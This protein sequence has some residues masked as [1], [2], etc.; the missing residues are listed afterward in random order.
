MVWRFS[1]KLLLIVSVCFLSALRA[2]NIQRDTLSNG[3]VILLSE[4]HKIPMVEI[5]VIVKAGSVLDPVGKAGLANLAAKM[6]I[7]GTRIHS[8][9]ELLSRIEYLGADLNAGATEDYAEISARALSKDL[10]LLLEIISECLT[11]PLFDT[12]EFKRLQR[13]TYSEIVSQMDDPFYIG[14]VEFRSLLFGKHPLNHDPLGFDSTINNISITDIKD[15]YNMYYASNNAALVLV[16]DFTYDSAIELMKRYFVDW[17]RKTITN[18][19]GTSPAVNGKRG[20]IVKRDISQS[21]IFFGFSGPDYKAKD[22]IQTRIMNYI[23][24]GSGLTS[25]LAT[26]IREKRGLAYDVFSFFDRFSYGGYFIAGV[27]TKNESA[28]EAINLIIQ[29]LKRISQDVHI[30]ELNR[31]KKYYIGNF[32]L[33]FDTYREMANFITKIEIEGLGLDYAD[34]FEGLVSAVTLKDI[35]ESAQ[36]YLHPDDFSLVIV[37]NIDKEAIKIKNIDWVR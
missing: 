7:R 16:G 32:P 27:Q 2:I 34:K 3:F 13:R 19:S 36:K 17:H 8:G 5:K 9:D 30:D 33:N 4:A 15:F 29:E 31:A 14:Q 18:F 24:G 10:P 11:K 20:L 23:L 6:L 26:E 12:I 21:Y 28:S 25:R 35:K 22:W 37:G 1:T